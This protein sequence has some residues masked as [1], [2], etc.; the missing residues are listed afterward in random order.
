MSWEVVMQRV[1]GYPASYECCREAVESAFALFPLNVK[2]K[3]VL[4]KPN[5]IRASSA[6]E[7]IVLTLR[8]FVPW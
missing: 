1:M 4:V 5:A 6:E 2:G 3:K 8:W 7:G